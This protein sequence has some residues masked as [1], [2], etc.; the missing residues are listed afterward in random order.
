MKRRLSI[1]AFIIAGIAGMIWSQ[2]AFN[3]I[4]SGGGGGTPGPSVTDSPLN[5]RDFGAIG[6]G[7]VHAITAA[8]ITANATKWKG[9]IQKTFSVICNG[10]S[11]ITIASGT[12]FDPWDKGARVYFPG[13]GNPGDV[14]YPNRQWLFINRVD[15][16]SRAVLKTGR[17]LTDE[18]SSIPDTSPTPGLPQT[19]ILE[20]YASGDQWDYVGLQE[21]MLTSFGGPSD[22]VGPASTTA[23]PAPAWP[24]GYYAPAAWSAVHL[25]K[26]APGGSGVWANPN[27]KHFNKAVHIPQGH[28]LI[29]KTIYIVGASGWRIYGDGKNSTM[30]TQYGSNHN[31]FFMDG[32]AYG[33]MSGIAFNGTTND[34]YHALLD[35]D[36]SE[37]F[38]SAGSLK[39]Q[40]ITIQDNAFYG[41]SNTGLLAENGTRV[42]FVAG[43]SGQGDTIT[44]L[45]NYWGYFTKM[46]VGMFG[47]N[48]LDN[49]IINGNIQGSSQYAVSM[50]IN[51]R[52]YVDG[53]DLQAGLTAYQ[54]FRNRAF[55]FAGV[56]HISRV[57]TEG[58][59]L[60]TGS[61][62]SIQNT[63]MSPAIT[64]WTA[65]ANAAMF[66]GNCASGSTTFTVT[67]AL[68]YFHPSDVGL[69]ITGNANIP[70]GTTIA[71]YVSDTQVTLSQPTTGTITAGAFTINSRPTWH[72]Q[73]DVIAPVYAGNDDGRM[74]VCVTAGASGSTEPVW[75]TAV[76]GRS[77]FDYSYS[78]ASGG[79]VVTLGGLNS[80]TQTRVAG[81]GVIAFGAGTGGPQ[82]GDLF[83]HI[84]IASPF[85]LDTAASVAVAT[86]T[87]PIMY[88]PTFFE[89]GAGTAEWM[90][91]DYYT[92]TQSQMVMNNDG[93]GRGRVSGSSTLST[94]TTVINNRFSRSDTTVPE[95]KAQGSVP[96]QRSEWLNIYIPGGK[97]YA[98]GY[99]FGN[100]SWATK[101]DFGAGPIIFNGQSSSATTAPDIGFVR[102]DGVSSALGTAA[103]DTRNVI[104]VVGSLGPPVA[105]GTNIAGGDFVLQGGPGSG[106]GGGGA[107]SL[108]TQT[109]GSSGTTIPNS[110]ERLRIDNV[111]RVT[112]SKLARLT[113]VTYATAPAPSEG[114]MMLFTD[115]NTN[116]HGATIASG[117]A[118]HVVGFYNGVNWVVLYP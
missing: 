43:G 54:T 112:F 85:T 13:S 107:I 62:Y 53:M 118:N 68:Y 11:T 29:N 115:S 46:A 89:G 45:N 31:I 28:F 72:Y 18:N 113:P 10:T 117:G 19:M 116:T 26:S 47:D 104:G 3:P 80:V 22:T 65:P 71:A 92:V 9:R 40:Q 105:V 98:V 39:P 15:S 111:G 95:I 49:F 73:G 61:N 30:L 101:F 84:S 81:M 1:A 33:S 114:D 102:N 38:G 24:A 27:N 64:R 6:D 23:T 76:P 93:L 60:S 87:Y 12:T 66:T 108:R 63:L 37:T 52:C 94:M 78:I 48:V 59:A 51:A 58:W 4:F 57:R 35:L 75:A 97:N 96:Q 70:A 14:G 83:A 86:D 8:D 2:S 109:A 55:D 50:G 77:G 99:T 7:N 25:N 34:R 91:F 103:G 5:P 110:T 32:C 20:G 21:T 44:W 67:N 82:G 79:T 106:S 42:C 17:D 69:T 100:R 74:Y 88:G 56:T 90:P 16:P 41:N 36:Y